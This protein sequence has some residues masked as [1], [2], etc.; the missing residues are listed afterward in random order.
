M[1]DCGVNRLTLEVTEVDCQMSLDII[2]DNGCCSW[3][4]RFWNIARDTNKFCSIFALLFCFRCSS[5]RGKFMIV[6][7]HDPGETVA[8]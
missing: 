7:I 5:G 4:V 2:D 6:S 1:K 3:L 8:K